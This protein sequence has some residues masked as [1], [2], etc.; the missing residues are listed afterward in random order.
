M[1]VQSIN[2]FITYSIITS[3]PAL[4][5]TSCYSTIRLHEVTSGQHAGGTFVEWSANFSGDA[6]ACESDTVHTRVSQCYFNLSLAVIED[7]KFKRREA[8]ADLGKA[9]TGKGQGKMT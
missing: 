8:L 3:Q 5:F 7:A 9:S 1:M 2:H 6:D 4:S